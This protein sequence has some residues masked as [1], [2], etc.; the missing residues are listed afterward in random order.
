MKRIFMIALLT[1][2]I[3]VMVMSAA[4]VSALWKV[5]RKGQ[6]QATANNLKQIGLALMV[7]ALDH[8]DRFPTE[9]GIA[10]LS[11]LRENGI[12]EKMLQA[13]SRNNAGKPSGDNKLTERDI[14]YAYLGNVLGEVR[15]ISHPTSTP[16]IIEKSSLKEGGKVLIL[17][18]DGHVISKEFGPTKLAEVVKTLMK[19]SGI[20]KDPIWPKLIEAASAIDEKK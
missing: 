8:D 14:N 5:Q 4:P 3:G 18:C 19:E 9:A 13:P 2:L 7:Y 12:T 17:F 6:E 1:G 20:E 11:A 16:I 15:K 10:G